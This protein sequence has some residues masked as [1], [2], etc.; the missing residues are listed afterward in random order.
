MQ[1]NNDGEDSVP[2]SQTVMRFQSQIRTQQATPQ[3]KRNLAWIVLINSSI[4]ELLTARRHALVLFNFGY[5][6]RVTIDYHFTSNH[7]NSRFKILTLITIVTIRTCMFYNR[8][9]MTSWSSD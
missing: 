7:L 2:N 3:L 1:R 6:N 4:L 9:F 8:L 5:Y